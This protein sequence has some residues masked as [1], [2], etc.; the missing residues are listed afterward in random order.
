MVA[1]F[2]FSHPPEATNGGNLIFFTGKRRNIDKKNTKSWVLQPVLFLGII[3]G[4]LSKLVTSRGPCHS[5][6]FGVK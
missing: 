1:F 3:Q 2:P 6:D 4:G 5:T